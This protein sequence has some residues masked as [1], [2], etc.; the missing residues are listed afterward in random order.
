MSFNQYTVNTPRV[1]MGKYMLEI[2]L[3]NRMGYDVLVVS[4][5]LPICSSA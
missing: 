1:L 5:S 2:E 4:A 3:L